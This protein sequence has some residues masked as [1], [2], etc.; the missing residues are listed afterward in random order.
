M[1]KQKMYHDLKIIC[2]AEEFNLFALIEQSQSERMLLMID[3]LRTI[4]TVHQLDSNLCVMILGGR[5]AYLV[6]NPKFRSPNSEH[7]L[8]VIDKASQQLFYVLERD[9]KIK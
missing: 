4:A 9:R 1:L 8:W 2:I 7:F 3:N 6:C 5:Q